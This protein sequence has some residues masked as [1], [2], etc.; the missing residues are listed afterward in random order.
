MKKLSILILFL[1]FNSVLFS[2]LAPE[3]YNFEEKKLAKI[4]DNS[5]VSNSILDIIVNGNDVWLGTS[6]GVSK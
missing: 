4:S 5:P 3:T 6:R 2:Q 1:I